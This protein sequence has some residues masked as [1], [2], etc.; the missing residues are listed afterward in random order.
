MSFTPAARRTIEGFAAQLGVE[1]RE[2]ADGS[3]SFR[4]DRSGQL[5]FTAGANGRAVIS[6]ARR[7]DVAGEATER[8]VLGLARPDAGGRSFLHAGMTRD[9]TVIFA[10]AMDEA[11]LDLPAIETALQR[12]LAAQAAIT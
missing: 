2:A 12:L 4:F 1:T 5:T 3:H 7:P 11:D 8:R 6:L 9:G 10:L